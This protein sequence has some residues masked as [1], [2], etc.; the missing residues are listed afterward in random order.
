MLL[1][2]LLFNFHLFGV[3]KQVGGFSIATIF[4]K[5]SIEVLFICI[6]HSSYALATE[7]KPVSRIPPTLYLRRINQHPDFPVI[8]F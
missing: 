4:S 1:Y 5:K 6:Q 8:L 7:D 3:E 2:C